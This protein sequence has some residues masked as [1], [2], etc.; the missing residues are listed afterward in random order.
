MDTFE[1]QTQASELKHTVLTLKA[2]S[3]SFFNQFVVGTERDNIIA[4]TA[5]PE[6]YC[7]LYRAMTDLIFDAQKKAVALEAALER[8]DQ[9]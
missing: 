8:S 5:Q 4:V 9:K 3:N 7:Y 2:I 1:L 6:T